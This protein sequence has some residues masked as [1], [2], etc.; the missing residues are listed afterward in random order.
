MASN[1]IAAALALF[2]SKRQECEAEIQQID[3]AIAQLKRWKAMEAPP[4]SPSVR[5]ASQPTKRQEEGPTI[6]EIFLRLLESH[7]KPTFRLADMVERIVRS[8]ETNAPRSTVY[9]NL[10]NHLKRNSHRYAKVRRGIYRQKAKP[11]EEST[12]A[13]ASSPIEHG[14]NAR[15]A[16]EEIEP[17]AIH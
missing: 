1:D 4:V 7:D 16:R 10:T 12:T 11:R 3:N 13:I 9:G 6:A 8:G 17:T 15:L 2:E 14:D 5:R